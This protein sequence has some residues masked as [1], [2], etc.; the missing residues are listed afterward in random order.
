MYLSE[1]CGAP[2]YEPGYPDTDLCGQ[3]KEHTGAYIEEADKIFDVI[4]KEFDWMEY[5]KEVIT[6]RVTQYVDYMTAIVEMDAIIESLRTELKGTKE[7][8]NGNK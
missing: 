1:C 4:D 6:K 5:K 3:C 8:L 2:F 7:L